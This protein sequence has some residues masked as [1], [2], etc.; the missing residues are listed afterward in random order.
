MAD[1]IIKLKLVNDPEMSQKLTICQPWG[2]VTTKSI[3]SDTNIKF[4]FSH[5]EEWYE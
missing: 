4:D 3:I 5:S 1:R 2:G